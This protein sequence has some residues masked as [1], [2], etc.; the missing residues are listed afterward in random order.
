MDMK[1]QLRDYTRAN[2]LFADSV[3][4]L[5]QKQNAMTALNIAKSNLDIAL[6]NRSHS[7]IV[8]P[9]NGLILKQFVRSNEL[10]SPGLPCFSFR[11]LR[12]ELEN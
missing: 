10:A 9:E 5:E 11:D 3:A 7:K 6:F 1:K 4:T 8:A 12:E 2:N